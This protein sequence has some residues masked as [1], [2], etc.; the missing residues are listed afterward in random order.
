M[1]KS[2]SFACK[3][4]KLNVSKIHKKDSISTASL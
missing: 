4:A 1:E 2:H 3:Q